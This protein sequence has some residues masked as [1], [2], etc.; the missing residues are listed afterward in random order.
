[1][2]ALWLCMQ[3]FAPAPGAVNTRL[4]AGIGACLVIAFLLLIYSY[5]RRPYVLYWVTGWALTA[6]SMFLAAGRYTRPSVGHLVYGLSQFFAVAAAT[7]FVM[8]ADA[9]DAPPRLPRW[10]VLALVL[11]LIWFTLAPIPLGPQAVFASGHLLTAGTLC[12][13]G[14]GYLAL[15]QR[16]RMVGAALVGSMLVL[17]AAANVWIALWVPLPGDVRAGRA[18]FVS[19]G[20]YLMAALGM[21]LFAFEDMTLELR[22]ANDRLEA[23]QT[24][25]KQMVVTDPLTGCRNRRF[26]DQVIGRELT[27]HRREQVPLSMLFIDIDHFKRINDTL[28]HEAGD[29]VLREV[30]GFVVRNVRGADYVFRW[31]GDEF[32]VLMS[33]PESQARRRGAALQ[34]AFKGSD[35]AAVLPE[36]V[37]LSIGSVEVPLDTDDVL[38]QVKVADDRMYENKRAGK[39]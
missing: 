35:E 17:V 13:A 6:I 27:R 5:R 26:F 37:G 10:Y 19:L 20:L 30:A 32:L 34:E 9:Y 28:G 38:Q 14:F 36:G 29:R 25:L 18:L 16:T 15:A 2:L 22:L 39:R 24:D 3:V 23:A 4:L 31:G 8:G 1:M 11:M 33:C 21:Q 12:A 7:A